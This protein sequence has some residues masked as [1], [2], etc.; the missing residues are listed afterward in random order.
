LRFFEFATILEPRL[1]IF[2][3][4]DAFLTDRSRLAASGVTCGAL[5]EG[6]AA[7]ISLPLPYSQYL[8]TVL[9]H[10]ANTRGTL[11]RLLASATPTLLICGDFQIISCWML[12]VSY[13]L[14]M[15]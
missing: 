10:A 14:R 4:M 12:P 5:L 8:V 2:G 7:G 11:H 9:L 15:W 1:V 3:S 13:V 6:T